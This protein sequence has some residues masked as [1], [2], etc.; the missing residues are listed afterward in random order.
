MD[1]STI[2]LGIVLAVALIGFLTIKFFTRLQEANN[3]RFER[4]EHQLMGLQAQVAHGIIIDNRPIARKPNQINDQRFHE[5]GVHTFNPVLVNNPY[6]QTSA[7]TNSVSIMGKKDLQKPSEDKVPAENQKLDESDSVESIERGFIGLP[8][9]IP[10]RPLDP[11]GQFLNSLAFD[12]ISIH[13]NRSIV[14]S[15]D[16]TGSS[17]EVDENDAV[18]CEIG[19]NEVVEID[20]NKVVEIGENEVVEIDENKVVEIDENETDEKVFEITEL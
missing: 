4:V 15:N 13:T 9:I 6:V 17:D 14:E 16:G 7:P 18:V 12:M 1:S 11:I 10:Q 5:L 20:E 8:Q 2:V 3:I 19:E